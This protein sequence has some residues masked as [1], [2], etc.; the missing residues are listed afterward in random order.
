MIKAA[1]EE[2]LPL[3]KTKTA[4]LQEDQARPPPQLKLD[5]ILGDVEAVI[6]DSQQIWIRIFLVWINI[7]LTHH[8]ND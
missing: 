2:T 7:I 6:D 1:R 3:L 8:H 5:L 4:T